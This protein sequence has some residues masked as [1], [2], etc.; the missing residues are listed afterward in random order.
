M[1]KQKQIFL[2]NE[3]DNWFSRNLDGL[4]SNDDFKDLNTI[5]EFIQNDFKI[6]EIGCSFGKKL[7][8]IRRKKI[9]LNLS[10]HGID[11]SKKS[12]D[13]GKELFKKIDLKVGTSDLLSFKDNTFDLVILGFCL[14]LVD[15]DLIFKTVSE[16]DRVLKPGR[17]IVITD[18]EP[19]Y[20]Y[21]KKYH[22][23]DGIYSF[24][25]NY[26]N[27]FLG[28]SHYSLVKKELFSHSV[29]SFDPLID[30]RVSTSV[31]Y[32]EIYDEIYELKK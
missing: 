19:T 12:I 21:R 8:V 25:N 15:R 13:K 18:F 5:F 11:P 31:L 17:F 7:D 22:H 4:L 32:K 29:S 20:P 10:L 26:S 6:L 23:L 2:E 27:F 14:Y 16:V 28:G 30:E 9:D 24:K 1:D 3:G